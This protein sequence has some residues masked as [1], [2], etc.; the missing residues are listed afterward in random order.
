MTTITDIAYDTLDA[1]DGSL[2]DRQLAMM[3]NALGTAV[4]SIADLR[5][6]YVHDQFANEGTVSDSF[7]IGH[8]GPLSS[9]D[10]ILAGFPT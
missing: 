4:G 1:F 8:G 2:R 6:L 5:Q 3:R 10:A 9:V 7:F